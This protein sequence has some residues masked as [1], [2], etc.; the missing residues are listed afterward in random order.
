MTKVFTLDSALT[1]AT[2]PT[3]TL[4]EDLE[5]Q[6][7]ALANLKGW[8]DASNATYRTDVSGKC[9]QLTDRSGQANH[10]IQATD[11]NRPLVSAAGMGTLGG[12][13][14]DALAFDG[15]TDLFM[16]TTNNAYDG[17]TVWTLAALL[18]PTTAAG[19]VPL[20]TDAAAGVKLS[21]NSTNVGDAIGNSVTTTVAAKL[22]IVHCYNYPGSG[23]VTDILD[24]NGTSNTL[25]A[26]VGGS[27][28]S[29]SKLQL[30]S[31]FASRAAKYNGKF[32]EALLFKADL[33]GVAGAVALLKQ[34]FTFKYR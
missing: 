12:V 10:I 31:A 24:V 29:A 7:A 34:Y 3:V 33:S 4:L 15:T 27:A 20:S 13:A 1:D 16:K 28:P 22:A 21:M 6:I 8:W 11:A 26:A 17:T 23:N 2:L 25:V 14:R 19:Q 32:S 30:G 18:Q 5:A 9:S